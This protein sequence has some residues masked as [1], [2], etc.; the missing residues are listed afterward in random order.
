MKSVILR[1]FRWPRIF[2]S[3]TILALMVFLLSLAPAPVSG[4][5]SQPGPKTPEFIPQELLVRFRAAVPPGRAD[6][7][8]AGNGAARLRR[9]DMLGIE[10]LG[11]PPGLEV[12]KAAEIFSRL[13]E[14]EFAE[15]NYL[16]HIAQAAGDWQQN[17]WAPQKIQAP[18]AWSQIPNPAD[19]TI[20]VVD[21]GVDY[22]HSQLRP[23]MWTNSAELK[24]QPGI[25]DDG[26]GYIDD[27]YGYDFYNKDGD[28][29]GDHFHGTHVA[30]IAAATIGTGPT[31]MAGV[32]PF[33]RIMAVKVLGADGSGGL[34]VVASGIT[35]AAD[36]GARVINLS[37]GGSIGMATLQT[38][39]DYA[40]GKGAVVVAAAGND[41]ADAR[42]Y[43]AAYPNAIAVAATDSRDYHACFSNYGNSTTTYISVAAPG[44][45]I[46][47]TAPLD[48]SGSDTYAV[49]S[50][51]S[52]ATPHVSG[53]AGLLFAQDPAR[54]NT[55]VR[56]LIQ[57]TTND[58]GSTGVDPFFGTGRINAYRAVMNIRDA[59]QPPGGL[60]ADSQTA[61]GYD[62]ARKLARDSSGTLHLIWHA[63]DG[64]AYK[65][66][67]ATST[68]YGAAWTLQP[69]VF[70][71]SLETY[72][73]SMAVDSTYI[74]AAFPVKTG[75]LSTSPYQILFTRKS[76][77]GGAWSTPVG[78]LGGTYNAVRPDLYLDPTN[79][80][81]HLVASSLDDAPYVYYR[82]SGNQGATWDPSRSV[83]PT[84][85][86]TASNTRY[87]AVHAN[88]QNIYIA[89][90]TVNSSLFTYYYLHTVRSTD[91][92]LT[93]TDQTKISSYLALTTGEYGVSLSG[94]GDRLYMAYEVGGGLYFRRYDGAGWSN[95][96]KLETAGKWPSIT[97]A[98]DGQ[99]WMAWENG[100][101]LL[102][103][104][105]TGVTWE[106]G[107]TLLSGNALYAGHYPN[108]KLDTSADQLEWVYTACCGAPFSLV[109]GSRQVGPAPQPTSTNT[110]PAVPSP[111]GTDTPTPT[112]TQTPTPT[113][114]DTPTPTETRTPTLTPTQ[115][116]T[117]TRTPTA[118]GTGT[119]TPTKTQTLTST[120]TRTRTVTPTPTRTPKKPGKQPTR[121]PTPVR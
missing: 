107:E 48:A 13:P 59:T 22:R 29:M 40:W 97:Q 93:W 85:S 105:Y 109:Y 61:T 66:R 81:L 69:D 68:D 80:R 39:V 31:S 34:D 101:D 14:V 52:M 33:C 63:K 77:S 25:D 21:T 71:S 90:R 67:Y 64:S 1:S 73:P 115:A 113:A 4:S 58:L 16:L 2:R 8:I 53:L 54:S 87:A 99:A 79:G 41:G 42:L 18:D 6:Q 111:T 17:Q 98:E 51:T 117:F 78:L 110:P 65:V 55:Q 89:A 57:S 5:A 84:T 23:N 88:G 82:A 116:S 74:Y 62:N 27:V 3:F 36:N 96:L 114:T 75:T 43:P 94:V 47:S 95:Y 102:L 112:S 37:L 35:Y 24:G 28:P 108:L 92:G 19:V 15:P 38:A 86:T 10:V 106:A 100:S 45:A 121:T 120:P 20:A 119:P 12:E 104:H 83:N 46:Y 44:Q 49:Y 56:D 70:T 30:G 103:R 50:G 9:V 7:L 118:T 11:L 60:F 32:C 76:L 91:G 26:N 72:H